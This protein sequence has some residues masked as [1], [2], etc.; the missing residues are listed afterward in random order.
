[1]TK[2]LLI[3]GSPRKGNTDFVLSKIYENISDDKELIFL[4]EKQIKHCIGCLNCHNKPE[5]V[6]NDDMSEIRKKMLDSDVLI[7][8]T[9]NYFDNISGL[10]KDFVD[11]THPFYKAGLLK[12]KKLKKPMWICTSRLM[13]EASDRMG[14]TDIIENAGGHIVADTCM[15]VSPIE[16]MGFNITGV[17]SGKAANYL[18][19]FCKQ[20]VVFSNID[21]LVEETI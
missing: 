5:C 14:Y 20:K 21:N 7:I 17:N 12:G 4:R 16:K 8:G 13:K 2:A 10:L 19:G 18:P 15:V 11:R 9:P 1:M 6:I 3:S